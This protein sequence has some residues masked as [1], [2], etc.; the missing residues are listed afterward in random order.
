MRDRIAL[1]GQCQNLDIKTV[2]MLNHIGDRAD[3]IQVGTFTFIVKGFNHNEIDVRRDTMVA[4][5]SG[6]RLIIACL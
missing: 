2:A 1:K 3:D 6:T 5:G 4:T